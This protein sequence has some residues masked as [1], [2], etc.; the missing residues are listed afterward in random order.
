MPIAHTDPALR[1]HDAL[2]PNPA[3]PLAATDPELIDVATQLLL[4]IGYSRT[5]NALQAI[6]EVDS[7]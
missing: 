5:L 3:S 2:F 4:L 1:N 7:I 6:D